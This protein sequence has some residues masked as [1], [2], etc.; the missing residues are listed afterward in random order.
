MPGI[1]SLNPFETKSAAGGFPP[2]PHGKPPSL[3]ITDGMEAWISPQP[4][5][6]TPVRDGGLGGDGSA[7]G[8]SGSRSAGPS[9]RAPL[10]RQR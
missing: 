8:E 2:N 6:E 9:P 3:L 7:A 10:F 5:D 4:G 1:G